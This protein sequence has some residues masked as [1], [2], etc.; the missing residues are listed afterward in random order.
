[1]GKFLEFA[2]GNNPEKEL[3]F[4]QQFAEYVN[5]KTKDILLITIL[6]KNFNA[7]S[8]DLTKTQ[9]DEWNKVKGRGGVIVLN[10]DGEIGFAY[11][12]PR[13]AYAYIKDGKVVKGV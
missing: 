9:I 8:L 2:S 5:D 1:M 13:M 10:R 12:T 11:N 4:I 6:H 3:Y 7:Y